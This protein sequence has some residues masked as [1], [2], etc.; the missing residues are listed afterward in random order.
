[1]PS[2]LSCSTVPVRS[3]RCISGTGA[4]GS[5]ANAASCKHPT[6]PTSQTSESVS[7]QHTG[8]PYTVTHTAALPLVHNPEVQ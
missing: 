7:S 8:T 2:A 5:A 1:M 4:S 6:A 3:D